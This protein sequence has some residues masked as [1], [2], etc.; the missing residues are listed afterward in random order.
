MDKPLLNA[1]GSDKCSQKST[2]EN[3]GL[4]SGL[5]S[6]AKS[7]KKGRITE[8]WS[9]RTKLLGYRN[10]QWLAISHSLLAGVPLAGSSLLP[11]PE[12]RQS[13]VTALRE[14]VTRDWTLEEKYS[15]EE[16]A[17]SANAGRPVSDTCLQG[18]TIEAEFQ[19]GKLAY[20]YISRLETT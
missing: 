10:Y 11:A 3:V 8:S 16:K 15:E 17:K 9:T 12:L 20:F 2:I 13:R 7:L 4:N 5:N 6:R 1:E 18:I 14:C 19:K